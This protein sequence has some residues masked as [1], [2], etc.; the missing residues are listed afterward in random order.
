MKEKRKADRTLIAAIILF[1]VFIVFTASV[2]LADVRAIG[3]EGSEVGYAA[4]NGAIADL[5]G[6]H[7]SWYKITNLLGYFAL[8]ICACF[9]VLGAVQLVRRKSI[10][11]VDPEILALGGFYVA[12]LAFYALFEVI[13]VNFRP[14]LID[15]ELEASY[16]S[17]H[18]M[19]AVCVFISAIFVLRRLFKGEKRFLLGSE[20]AFTVLTAVTIIGRVVSGVHWFTDII[21]GCL[22]SAA[23]IVCFRFVLSLIDKRR[24]E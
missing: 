4:L 2:K 9:A 8:L 7:M 23:L 21:G 1:A 19:L 20:C 10:K 14:V 3:P 17:S 15:G 16:P 11:K 5:V 24:S 12:V 13:S 18:T 6:V 22:L